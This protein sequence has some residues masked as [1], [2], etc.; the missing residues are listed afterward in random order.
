MAEAVGS[1]RGNAREHPREGEKAWRKQFCNIEFANA[2]RQGETYV[3]VYRDIKAPYTHFSKYT[4]FLQ[5]LEKQ[6]ISPGLGLFA[7]YCVDREE[8]QGSELNE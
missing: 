2:P 1:S 4:D 6:G 8:N 7:E 5:C 3:D